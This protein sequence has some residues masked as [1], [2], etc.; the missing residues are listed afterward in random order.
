[1][2]AFVSTLGADADPLA[3]PAGF[4]EW[5]T[6]AGLLPEGT[7]LTEDDRQRALE[8]RQGLAALMMANSGGKPADD[9][10]ERLRQAVDG[11]HLRLRFDDAGPVGFEPSGFPADALAALLALVAQA[12]SSGRWQLLK[13]CA[14]DGCRRAFYDTSRGAIGKYCTRQC[15][16]RVRAK[17]YR[18][19]DKYRSGYRRRWG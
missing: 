10:V 19:T 5:L 15:G 18:K 2:R 14:R 11:A 8:V 4:G 3:T 6:S 1:M 9:A 13:I 7:P 12:R 17:A 16:D